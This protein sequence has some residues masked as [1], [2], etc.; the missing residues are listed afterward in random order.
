MNKTQLG[1]I[2]EA[3]TNQIFWCPPPVCLFCLCPRRHPATSC[4]KYPCR[5]RSPLVYTSSNLKTHILKPAW[6]S[7]RIIWST[8]KPKISKPQVEARTSLRSWSRGSL[9]WSEYRLEASVGELFITFHIRWREWTIYLR[10]PL[11]ILNKNGNA[12]LFF[13]LPFFHESSP[14]I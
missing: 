5:K 13:L 14:K 2:S 6:T 10:F 8:Q 3:L 4:M 7:S 11:N 1:E 9:D 12:T